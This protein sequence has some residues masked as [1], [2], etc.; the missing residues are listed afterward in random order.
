MREHRHNK[1]EKSLQE[2]RRQR[3]LQHAPGVPASRC[4]KHRKIQSRERS[5][6]SSCSK[7]AL[8][9]GGRGGGGRNQ[10]EGRGA[11]G[12]AGNGCNGEGHSHE[13]EPSRSGGFDSSDAHRDE[14]MGDASA[15]PFH[16]NSPPAHA[17]APVVKLSSGIPK[18]PD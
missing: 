15:L 17:K 1:E 11:G 12:V 2:E 13:D 10:G 16:T 7:T 3:R 6:P 14:L 8:Q 9:G 18:K 5:S 4:D